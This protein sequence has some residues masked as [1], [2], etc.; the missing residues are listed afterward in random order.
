MVEGT[1]EL[2]VSTPFGKQ[3]A[4]LVL[5]RGGGVG[6]LNGRIDSRLGSVPLSNLSVSADGFDAI[7]SMEFQGRAYDARVTGRVEGDRLDGTIK[8]N[9]PI[10][11]PARFT[12][13][14]AG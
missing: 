3:P 13:T 9:L 10:A 8:V 7:A 12:G 2:E 11:P 14:R 5:E 6:D 4:T 1:W